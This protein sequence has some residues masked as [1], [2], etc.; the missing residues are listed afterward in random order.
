M[1]HGIINVNGKIQI[2]VDAAVQWELVQ[3][4]EQQITLKLVHQE[5]GQHIMAT[6]AM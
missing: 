4:T 3:E 6:V 5:I 2:Y 1:D